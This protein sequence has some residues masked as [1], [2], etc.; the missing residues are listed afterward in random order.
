MIYHHICFY[1]EDK[2]QD[3]DEW[4][5]SN[6]ESGVF[7]ESYMEVKKIVSFQVFSELKGV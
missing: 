3:V 2:I 6:H 4:I 5:M 7:E 1:F